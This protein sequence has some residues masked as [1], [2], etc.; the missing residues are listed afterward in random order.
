MLKW[1]AN[2]YFVWIQNTAPF[3]IIQPLNIFK[4]KT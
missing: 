4:A 2:N 1:R 3:K